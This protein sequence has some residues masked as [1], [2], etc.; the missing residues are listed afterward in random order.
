[1]NLKFVDKLPYRQLG[2]SASNTT[3][4]KV[5]H[6]PLL[7]T[8]L[9]E[10]PDTLKVSNAHNVEVSNKTIR[11]WKEDCL[12]VVR[13]TTG[14]FL[15]LT[16]FPYGKN[17]I[18]VKGASSWVVLGFKLL[19]NGRECDVEIG[20]FDNYWYPGRQPTRMTGV[21]VDPSGLPAVV[22]L[23]DA[24]DT[25]VF[26]PHRIVRVPRY[27]WLPYF[28]YRYTLLRAGNLWRRL[29]KRPLIPTS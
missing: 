4:D 26:G 3:D 1:M 24:E 12:D 8:G 27:V 21:Y 18:T 17:A 11:N 6:L 10:W 16:L 22:K 2:P 19:A 20:G 9:G 23:W 15:K 7:E 13:V 5:E 29:T 25:N 28:L 14:S